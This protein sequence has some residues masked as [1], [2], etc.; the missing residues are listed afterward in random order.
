MDDVKKFS[1]GA[2]NVLVYY[3]DAHSNKAWAG[4]LAEVIETGFTKGHNVFKMSAGKCYLIVTSYKTFRT[5]HGPQALL[6]FIES[7]LPHMEKNDQKKLVDKIEKGQSQLPKKWL[8]NLSGQFPFISFD[9]AHCL[10][11]TS[12]QISV[13]IRWLDPRFRYHLT[14]SPVP[15]TLDNTTN[16]IHSYR[17]TDSAIQAVASDILSCEAIFG[18]D[19]FKWLDTVPGVKKR[20]HGGV[21]E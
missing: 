20:I 12:S 7:K 17:Y 14:A 16:L 3:G 2:L 9:E 18:D 19:P 4:G 5:R 1:G 8:G 15:N 10:A 21:F 6:K 13:A 11:S